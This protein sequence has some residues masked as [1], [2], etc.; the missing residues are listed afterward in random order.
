[1]D[2]K[3]KKPIKVLFQ[4]RVELFDKRGGDTYQMECTKEAIEKLYPN[5]KIDIK[6]EIEVKNIAEYDIVN[7]FNIDWICETY[8]QARYAKKFN[9]LLVLSAIHHSES[10]VL[11]FENKCRFGTRRVFNTLIKNQES[12]DVLKNF[13]RSFLYPLKIYPTLLQARM[14][15]KNQQRE[16]LRM[17]DI[18]LVQTNLE[19]NEII[20]DIGTS[21]FKSEKV[22]SGVNADIFLKTNNRTF[23]NYFF[24]KYNRRIPLDKVIMS[25]GRIE[26]RKNQ[27]A[28]IEAFSRLRKETSAFNDWVLVFIGDRN[29]YHIEYNKRFNN[30]IKGCEDIY[31]LG[32]LPQ[33]LV[34]SAMSLAGICVQASWFETLGLASLEAAIA[35]MRVVATGARI[36]EYLRNYATYC[37]PGDVDSI[38][39]AI[40]EARKSSP[41]G[42]T[43]RENLIKEY[44]WEETARQTV[45]VYRK[46]LAGNN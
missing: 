6:P 37:D 4:S 43:A 16:V 44:T 8:P 18:V 20:K 34:S 1:M 5:F 42:S 3:M 38:K 2:T 29:R 9:K 17:S 40:M 45:K 12:R 46:L 13:Y 10:E 24:R 21:N 31:Y 7:L 25:V 11:E 32:R 39:R 36:K 30:K 35:G 27:L 28:V 33:N 15:I 23:C 26:P 19:T 22:I 41:F 14:G